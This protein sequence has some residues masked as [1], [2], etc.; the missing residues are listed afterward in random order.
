[1]AVAP[2]LGFNVRIALWLLFTMLVSACRNSFAIG[3]GEGGVPHMNAINLTCK[4][5]C[6]TLGGVIRDK[7][8]TKVITGHH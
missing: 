6:C 2:S 1:M 3:G 4:C 5:D 8:N 7:D